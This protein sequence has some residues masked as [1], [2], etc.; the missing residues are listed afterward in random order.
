M[1]GGLNGVM[2]TIKHTK[3]LPLH[4]GGSDML[5]KV[6]ARCV[7]LTQPP[8]YC[9]Q[10]LKDQHLAELMLEDKRN[11]VDK[12]PFGILT[13]KYHIDS[14]L[15][16][17]KL[18]LHSCTHNGRI[19]LLRMASWPGGRSGRFHASDCFFNLS[20]RFPEPNLCITVETLQSYHVYP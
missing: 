3:Y 9:T 16:Q 14:K 13:T 20:E 7:A 17:Q 6:F 18:Q 12:G 19:R 10:A 5:P 1:T 8:S 15:L 11:K 2:F 4:V